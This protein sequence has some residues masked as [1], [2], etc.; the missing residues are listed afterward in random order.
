MLD[1]GGQ[2]QKQGVQKSVKYTTDCLPGLLRWTAPE[3]P[4]L[5]WTAQE[6]PFDLG[7]C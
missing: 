3:G 7:P 1:L 5:K 4:L 2:T 6:G